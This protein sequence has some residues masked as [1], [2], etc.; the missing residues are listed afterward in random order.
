MIRRL[1]EDSRHCIGQQ[2]KA[3]EICE[4]AGEVATASLLE[5]VMDTTEKQ[6]WFLY[7]YQQDTDRFLG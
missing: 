1:I 6:L 3:H 7:E 5:E 4:E 2:Q